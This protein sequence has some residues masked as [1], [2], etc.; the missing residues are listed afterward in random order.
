MTRRRPSRT[1]TILSMF[2]LLAIMLAVFATP[3]S[4][5][6]RHSDHR[7]DRL[8]MYN[9]PATMPAWTSFYLSNGYCTDLKAEVKDLLSR[10]TRVEFTLDGRPLRTRPVVTFD[11]TGQI[12]GV[13]IAQKH[14]E[15]DF[16]FGL[17]PGVHIIA[18]CWYWLGVQELC[19]A[20]V[21][22]FE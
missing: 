5:H 22:T 17:R 6:G 3:V 1:R 19:Q 14:D 18:G 11:P 4:A 7:G 15:V 8:N 9:P 20:A 16:R 13:C 2:A 12:D 10:T 21:I